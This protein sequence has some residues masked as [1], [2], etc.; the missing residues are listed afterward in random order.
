MPATRTVG[1]GGGS[2]GG[3]GNSDR[4]TGEEKERRKGGREREGQ[5]AVAAVEARGAGRGCA[6]NDSIFCAHDSTRA[7]KDEADRSPV[8]HMLSCCSARSSG[9]EP[10]SER[11]SERERERGKSKSRKKQQESSNNSSCACE[12]ISMGMR[13]QEEDA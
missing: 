4:Q 11:V 10:A 3:E 12:Y 6:R 1:A 7:E 13:V 8:Q 9:C 2:R 5:Q